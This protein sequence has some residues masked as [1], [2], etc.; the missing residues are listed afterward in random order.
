[1]DE[2][3]DGC[4]ETGD[5]GGQEEEEEEEEADPTVAPLADSEAPAED[6]EEEEETTTEDGDDGAETQPQVSYGAASLNPASGRCISRPEHNVMCIVNHS[7]TCVM[8]QQDGAAAPVLDRRGL[9]GWDHVDQLAAVL[10]EH[11]DR[12]SL[13]A[14]Q[15]DRIR[16]LWGQLE[17]ADRRPL[18]FGG[19]PRR[20]TSRGRFK[21]RYRPGGHAGVEAVGRS[22]MSR[23]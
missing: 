7:D 4:R 12:L 23:R 14:L 13:T 16:R 19:V 18:Q 3:E 10:V 6:E 21:R 17:E 2:G 15:A 20:T 9:P 11:G 8:C 5:V 1:M 22:V